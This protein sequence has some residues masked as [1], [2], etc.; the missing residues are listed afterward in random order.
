MD[1]KYV[2]RTDVKLSNA[3]TREEAIKAV[4]EY[5]SQGVSAYIVSETEAERIKDS[6]FNKPSWK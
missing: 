2:V 6:E 5:E 4:K 1:K 3:M